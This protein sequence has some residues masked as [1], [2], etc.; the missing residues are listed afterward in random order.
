MTAVGRGL[1]FGFALGALAVAAE[2]PRTFRDGTPTWPARAQFDPASPNVII[3]VL[4][5]IG[6][7]QLGCFGGPV[8]T[9]H[10]DR[11]AA[12][13]LRYSNFHTAPVCSPTRA[14]LLTGRNPHRVGMGTITEFA[15]GFPNS[16]GGI[17]PDARTLAEAL[18][19]RGY[20]TMAAG[21]WHLT[22]MEDMHSGGAAEHWPI[23][24]GFERFYGYMGGDTNQWAPELFQDRTRIVPPD[25]Q[26]DGRPYHLDAD[27]TDQAIGWISRQQAATPGRPF[28]LYLAY[29]AGHA[30]H[31]AP[32]E[33][34]DRQRGK[35]SA[36]WDVAREETLA[37]QKKLGLVPG[38]LVLPP[39]NPGVRPWRELS[40]EEQRVHARYYETFAGCLEHTDH[41]FG[42]LLDHLARLGAA[43]NTLL[44]VLSDNGASPEGGP[45]GI[46]NE[47]QLFSA[48]RGGSLPL[49][50][51]HENELGGPKTFPSYAIGWTQ[52]GNTPWRST[53]GTLF[54]GGTRVPLIIR[55]P[56]RI[57]TQGGV[58]SQ[59]H[60]VTDLA[61]TILE[62]ATA[63]AS[64]SGMDSTPDHAA[65]L[66]GVSLAY[67]WPATNAA[68]PSRRRSQV[69]EL[70]GHRSLWQDGWKI[71]SP[72]ASG[73]P[74]ESG[75]WQLYHLAVD[76]TESHDLAMQEAGKLRELIQA[77]ERAAA[78]SEVFPLDDRTGARD[79]LRSPE[80]LARTRAVY[81][82]P[83][84]GLHKATA[85]EYRRRSMSITADFRGHGDGVLVAQGGRFAGFALYVL[86]QRPVFHYNWGGI[87][88]TTVTARAPLA[89]DAA[90][91]TV[92]VAF[93]RAPDESA[94][95]TLWVD[96]QPAGEGRVPHAMTGNISHEPLDFGRDDYTPVSE[97]Y[98][99]PFAFPGEIRQVVIETTP[100]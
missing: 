54:E 9:P 91:H 10:F 8:A 17:R 76:P 25:T 83:L 89:A 74:L 85:L 46:W 34:I 23:G 66:D 100:R 4:D 56:A 64:K 3:V 78:A 93:T 21:K 67:S 48:E 88:R 53:K 32:A 81:F 82:P 13:G 45:H 79:V 37:R 62:A 38:D 71:I 19:A 70:H 18:H 60:F 40:A 24:R 20:N 69:F 57:A 50:L 58:R 26:P 14:A 11:V 61:P 15:N 96:G 30:P 65:A 73:Q 1:A 59:Y 94:V 6:F 86:N 90:E 68:A 84:A 5:D 80:N 75:H 47:V 27:L 63:P 12:Q 98:R 7:G 77:W 72:H 52:A 28:F 35:F 49:S 36:G 99:S 95:V 55:W 16:R 97:D 33:F 39:A 2:V 22:P 51:A 41:H 31:H 87:E 43:D 29:C 44:I 92:R 42:R